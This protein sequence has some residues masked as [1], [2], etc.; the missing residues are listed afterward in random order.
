MSYNSLLKTFF[1]LLLST[2]VLAASRRVQVQ[3]PKM[4]I[5]QAMKYIDNLVSS[6][7]TSRA[8]IA[9]KSLFSRFDVQEA[10]KLDISKTE[11]AIKTVMDG[12]NTFKDNFGD[13]FE[14]DKIKDSLQYLKD[15]AY[16]L[17]NTGKQSTTDSMNSLGTGLRRMDKI[18]NTVTVMLKGISGGADLVTE[19]YEKWKDL[20]LSDEKQGKIYLVG[21]R[22]LDKTLLDAL[23]TCGDVKDDLYEVADAMGATQTSFMSLAADFKRA[24]EEPQG[25]AQKNYFGAWVKKIASNCIGDCVGG[26][27]AGIFEGFATCTVCLGKDLYEAIKEE[28]KRVQEMIPKNEEMMRKFQEAMEQMVGFAGHIGEVAKSQA[29]AVNAFQGELATMEIDLANQMDL[30]EI[31]A[32]LVSRDDILHR[33]DDMR[34]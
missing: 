29:E 27:F 31:S 18:K 16:D 15:H 26:F 11:D 2:Q 25:D 7:T 1:L 19:M 30:I 28:N 22:S 6:I 14:A 21:L 34:G 4:S 8:N 32:V 13:F 17:L 5:T 33:M 23:K 12:L 10:K 20:E 9:S 24:A 3:P